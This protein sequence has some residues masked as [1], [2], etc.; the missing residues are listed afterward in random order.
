METIHTLKTV[1][2]HDVVCFALEIHLWSGRI[3][4]KADELKKFSAKDIALPDSALASLGSVKICDPAVIRAFETLKREAHYLLAGIGLPLF[5][6]SA[7]PAH[8]Y[9]EVRNKLDAIKVEFDKQAREL[10]AQYDEVIKKWRHQWEKENPGY[11]HLL[12]RIPKAETVFGRLSFDY[13]CYRVEPP[14]GSF[15]DEAGAEF[16]TKLSGLRGELYN[17]AAR[18]AVALIESLADKNGSKREYITPKTLGPIKRIAQRFRDFQAF[19][20]SAISAAELIET[21]VSQALAFAQADKKNRI[22]DG[23]MMLVLAMA[24]TFATPAAAARLAEKSRNEGA[25]A[26]FD[27]LLQMDLITTTTETEAPAE[28]S[29][30]AEGTTTAVQTPAVQGPFAGFESSLE[31]MRQCASTAQSQT[32]TDLADRSPANQI[33]L[34]PT[35]PEPASVS[36]VMVQVDAPADAGIDHF[37]SF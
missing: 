30:N 13:H 2:S 14:K 26:A 32:V 9:E 17:E 15:D 20:P 24:N 4:L 22:S 29:A 19:D 12:D 27:H 37:L 7:I 21:A 33:E 6:V 34:I 1:A 28:Q 23:P 18:E 8:R 35:I 36:T 31:A 5:K 16:T 11:G 3:Q 10:L 25:E